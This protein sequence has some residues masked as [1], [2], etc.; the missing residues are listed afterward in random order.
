M[1]RA[2]QA[3]FCRPLHLAQAGDSRL[4]ACTKQL[5]TEEDIS[6]AFGFRYCE[7][8]ADMENVLYLYRRMILAERIGAFLQ[9]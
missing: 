4:E 8:R 5:L 7:T 9:A 3:E 2:G 6:T 1:Y